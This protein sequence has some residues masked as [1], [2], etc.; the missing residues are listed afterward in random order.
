MNVSLTPELE[1]LI[2]L[3]VQSGRYATVSEVVADALRQMDERDRVQAVYR[4]EV[5]AQVDAGVASLRAGHL[6]DGEAFFDALDDE[7]AA[8]EDR[9][10]R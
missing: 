10:P 9:A 4:D 2:Q 3:K 5:R 8:L 1:Q 6:E 7:L